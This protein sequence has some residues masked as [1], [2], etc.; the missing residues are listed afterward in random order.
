MVY[1]SIGMA[2]SKGDRV[3][4]KP[5]AVA[6]YLGPTAGQKH[7]LV[8]YIYLHLLE[9]PFM[10]IR[11]IALLLAAI[12]ILGYWSGVHNCKWTEQLQEDT[13]T[14]PPTSKVTTVANA[15]EA[16]ISDNS[17]GSQNPIDNVVPINQSTAEAIRYTEQAKVALQ[18][19]DTQG[20]FENLD[21]AL[22]ELESIRGNLTL[23]AVALTVVAFTV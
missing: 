14:E 18:N 12:V 9:N 22:N 19:N 15:S 5:P 17:G 11:S 3:N 2:D 23:S 20:A 8:V 4:V 13:A 21:L 1:N 10:L 16:T 6:I 7:T